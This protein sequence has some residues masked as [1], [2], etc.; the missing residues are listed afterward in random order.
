MKIFTK[1][2]VFSDS[3]KFGGTLSFSKSNTFNPSK[4]FS[5]S[6]Q[7]SQSF[8]FT[9]SIK[10]I[11]EDPRCIVYDSES[12]KLLDECK[13]TET[14]E[15]LA[16]V[17]VLVNNFT[18]YRQAENGSAT[19][20]VNCGIQCNN[21]NFLD[22]ISTSGFGG[23]I[24]YD[25][26]YDIINNATFVDCVFQ[27]W[28]ALIGGGVF[29]S[30]PQNVLNVTFTSCIFELNEAL[31]LNK[32]TGDKKIFYGGS[33]MFFIGQ[34][35]N[36]TKCIFRKNIGRE[37]A[38]KIIDSYNDKSNSI[39]LGEYKSSISFVGC[40]FEKDENSHS[41]IYYFETKKIHTIVNIVHCEFK[42]KLNEKSYYVDS[43]LYDKENLQ[44]TSC[45][46]GKESKNLVNIDLIDDNAY[47]DNGENKFYIYF[48]VMVIVL[49]IFFSLLFFIM[50]R[51]FFSNKKQELHMN[52][53]NENS[54][55]NDNL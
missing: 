30:C 49:A 22:C 26:S 37:G 6:L 8:D 9:P 34:N 20:L 10:P 24:Y 4:L 18:N 19:Y 33:A 21:S 27:R 36:C 11:P 46:F 45:N 38:V 2:A 52:E 25:N 50:K 29:L 17:Y 3:K 35:L 40:N 42:G 51:H 23:A 16:Y 47:F 55:N 43:K 15:K 14:K 13:Y 12:S 41:S 5:K 32:P 1:S 48:K 28:K 31:L 54:F 44:I 7:F 53:L 39:Q